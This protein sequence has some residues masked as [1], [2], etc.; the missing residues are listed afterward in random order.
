MGASFARPA[1]GAALQHVRGPQAG[2][3]TVLAGKAPRGRQEP[4][5]GR[6]RRR[7]DARPPRR[8]AD[9]RPR[10]RA[11]GRPRQRDE[12]RRDDGHD[13]DPLGRRA[14]AGR[15]GGFRRRHRAGR[16]VPRARPALPPRFRADHVR[17]FRPLGRNFAARGCRR[18]RLARRIAVA[19]SIAARRRVAARSRRSCRA[20]RGGGR[21]R[22]PAAERRRLL[23]ARRQGAGTARAS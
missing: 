2:L 20:R 5:A 14:G 6:A 8:R 7:A 12:V 23:P 10:A 19:G 3:R 21:V 22:A 4:S 17:G 15:L 13:R 9:D 1:V 16:R 11:R 18:V